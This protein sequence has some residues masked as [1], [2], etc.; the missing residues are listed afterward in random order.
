VLLLIVAL[1]ASASS[2]V[3]AAK[4]GSNVEQ[5]ATLGQEPNWNSEHWEED[6]TYYTAWA[7]LQFC[8]SPDSAVNDL[9]G[10]RA[11]LLGK[12]EPT[13][14]EGTLWEMS[15]AQGS[16]W[17]APTSEDALAADLAWPYSRERLNGAQMLCVQGADDHCCCKSRGTWSIYA[18]FETAEEARHVWDGLRQPESW[19]SEVLCIG[20]ADGGVRQETAIAGGHIVREP[21]G[22]GDGQQ[23][24]SQF[25]AWA[26]SLGFAGVFIAAIW[27]T[28]MFATTKAMW[29]RFVLQPLK[30]YYQTKQIIR[31]ETA[32]ARQAG[33]LRDDMQALYHRAVHGSGHEPLGSDDEAMDDQELQTLNPVENPIMRSPAGK[34]LARSAH[35]SPHVI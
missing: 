15:Q 31:I 19:D 24:D 11:A 9:D 22:T 6:R 33:K 16:T 3:N 14:G 8:V 1:A 29:S 32:V 17:M 28:C 5:A 2:A 10:L 12:F 35:N 18:R 34:A 23:E 7:H 20:T 13:R 25:Q 26:F 21:L 30:R 27:L 4:A